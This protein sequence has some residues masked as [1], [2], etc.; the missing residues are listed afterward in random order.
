[1]MYAGIG[2]R[3]SPPEMCA[4]MTQLASFLES[5]GLILRSGGAAG[6]D[7]AFEAGVK[8]PTKKVVYTAHSRLSQDDW[9]YGFDHVS[10][11]HPTPQKVLE[12][13][14]ARI[15]AR[16]TFQV[17][18]TP[19]EQAA[20]QPHSAFVV[21]WTPDGAEKVTTRATGGTGQ[22]IRIAAHYGIPVF[23][24]RVHDAV[25]RLDSFLASRA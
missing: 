14:W 6:A 25:D 20:G 10:W 9:Q 3:L 5:K 22:A 12:S 21:C 15:M 18:G 23:N 24:L 17:L 8:D 13:K 19:S 2:S 4:Y 11:F 7:L 1:M 16:N